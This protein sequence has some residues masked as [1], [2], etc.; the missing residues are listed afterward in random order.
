MGCGKKAECDIEGSHAHKYTNEE[1]YI[2]Y[3]NKEYLEYDGYQRDEEYINIEGEEDLYKFI[4][5]HSLMRIDD[6]LDII[7][8]KMAENEDFIE[9]RYSYP[10]DEPIPH[11]S[12]INGITYTFYSYN[13]TT[14]YSWTKDVNQEN[15]TGEQRMCHYVYTGY[16]IAIDD[17][18]KYVLIPSEEVDDIREIMD[19]YPYIKQTYYKVIDINTGLEVDYENGPEQ[20]LDEED[21][22]GKVNN[23]EQDTE[24]NIYR[25]KL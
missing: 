18:G 1:G 23:L 17:N 21:F 3:I 2:R 5:Q 16:K 24:S 9:Y 11:Y 14:Y 15:L 4:D 8:A 10:Y 6:N 12:I 20:D 25:L 7:I 19:E 13:T 22:Q